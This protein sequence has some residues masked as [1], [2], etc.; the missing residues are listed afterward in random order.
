LR[1]PP[2]ELL[3]STHQFPGPY[4]FKV[5]GVPGTLTE[6]LIVEALSPHAQSTQ[7]MSTRL[8]SG[9]KHVSITVQGMMLNAHKVHDALVALHH[10]P[11]MT[12]LL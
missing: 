11:G 2:L 6:T 12:M 1:L 9:G 7:V 5:V 3:E 4:Y 8:S 10:L